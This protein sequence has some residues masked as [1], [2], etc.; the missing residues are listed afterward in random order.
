LNCKDINKNC[1]NSL[2]IQKVINFSISYSSKFERYNL[3]LTKF[4][5]NPFYLEK[6]DLNMIELNKNRTDLEKEKKFKI[7]RNSC[8][9]FKEN[10]TKYEM[11]VNNTYNHSLEEKINQKL[12]KL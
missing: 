5:K 4:S 12:S 3:E 7:E 11:P 1:T 2:V 9:V 6:N 10:D 8:F